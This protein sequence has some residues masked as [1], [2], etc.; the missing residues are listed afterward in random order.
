MTWENIDTFHLLIPFLLLYSVDGLLNENLAHFLCLSLILFTFMSHAMCPSKFQEEPPWFSLDVPWN[1]SHHRPFCGCQHANAGAV[2]S[3]VAKE[4]AGRGC[5][6]PTP[7][8]TTCHHP[9]ACCKWNV[10]ESWRWRDSLSSLRSSP[11]IWSIFRFTFW[12][13]PCSCVFARNWFPMPWCKMQE[14][15]IGSKC[16]G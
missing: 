14:E 11:L 6:V 10:W 4:E 7:F 13:Q 16:L 8:L 15:R 1:F 9:L 2:K 3:L 5:L 12:D